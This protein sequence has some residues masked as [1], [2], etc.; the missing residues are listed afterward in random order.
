MPA[1]LH[2]ELK[3]DDIKSRDKYFELFANTVKAFA[4]NYREISNGRGLVA[5]S[6]T[7]EKPKK[8]SRRAYVVSSYEEKTIC[9]EF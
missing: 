4:Q 8:R 2:I 3:L 5:V 6:T 1:F 9:Y 7:D